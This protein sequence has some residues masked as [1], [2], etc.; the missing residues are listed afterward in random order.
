MPRRAE[1]KLPSRSKKRLADSSKPGGGW[2]GDNATANEAYLPRRPCLPNGV[3]RAFR[4]ATQPISGWQI[5]V[6]TSFPPSPQ[7]KQKR[8]N[9]R[10]LLRSDQFRTAST[11][12]QTHS[13]TTKTERH[14][15]M[16]SPRGPRSP[17]HRK[18]RRW[19][20][21]ITSLGTIKMAR[22]VADG[23][24]PFLLRNSP[25]TSRS[26]SSSITRANAPASLHSFQ[27]PIASGAVADVVSASSSPADVDFDD[28]VA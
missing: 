15:A 25:T 12:A 5:L 6:S 1:R 7:A 24:A 17:V 4:D 13:S 11:D 20:R 27:T 16:P 28:A 9:C 26:A 22:R 19:P 14:R 10:R 8:S 21:Q 23:R 2:G 3:T 18:T